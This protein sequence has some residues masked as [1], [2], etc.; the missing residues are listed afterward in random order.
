MSN[1]GSKFKPK[2]IYPVYHCIHHLELDRHLELTNIYEEVL[3]PL[4]EQAKK[5]L[6]TGDGDIVDTGIV[7]YDRAMELVFFSLKENMELTYIKK[8]LQEMARKLK[9]WAVGLLINEVSGNDGNAS[10][11]LQICLYVESLFGDK[12]VV[13]PYSYNRVAEV[14]CFSSPR[15]IEEGTDYGK[16][17]PAGCTSG[18]FPRERN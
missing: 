1:N 18:I 6:V 15:N 7:I 9:A 4:V 17:L 5:A 10:Q 11:S 2:Y 16:V 3:E 12:H 8:G 14:A 13:Y